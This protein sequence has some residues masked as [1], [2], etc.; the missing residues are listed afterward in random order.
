M[1]FDSNSVLLKNRGVNYR[2]SVET[3]SIFSKYKFVPN[4]IRKA[5][6]EFNKRLD[7]RPHVTMKLK[8]IKADVLRI[9]PTS[10]DTMAIWLVVKEKDI[11]IVEKICFTIRGDVYFAD[12]SEE[13]VDH[14][15]IDDVLFDNN[16]G[17]F[18]N[19]K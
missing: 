12:D 13:N 8:G 1:R 7:K 16:H 15:V 2:H 19:K 9:V 18:S 5:V 14:M 3:P 17:I 4:V 10:D 6:E 11:D